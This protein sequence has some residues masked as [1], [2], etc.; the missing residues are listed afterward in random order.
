[1]IVYSV[2]L[3]ERSESKDP[4]PVVEEYG[5]FDYAAYDRSAQNDIFVTVTKLNNHLA[6]RLEEYS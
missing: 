1:M 4:F 6:S 5:F 2:I 3:S